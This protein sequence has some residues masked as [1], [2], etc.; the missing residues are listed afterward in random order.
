MTGKG[1]RIGSRGRRDPKLDCECGNTVGKMWEN[2]GSDV[3]NNTAWDSSAS[4]GRLRI[5]QAI[6]SVRVGAE[7]AS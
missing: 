4:P 2:G 7:V 3:D 5:A 6:Q 1:S